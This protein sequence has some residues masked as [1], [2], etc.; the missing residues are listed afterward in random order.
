MKMIRIIPLLIF[1]FVLATFQL[2]T[3]SSSSDTADSIDSPK[4]STPEQTWN[5]FKTSILAGDY[6]TAKKCCCAGKTKSVLR[7]EK[8]AD[9]K[10]K[11]LV[12]TMQTIKKIEQQEGTAKYEVVR[13][14]NGVDFSTFVYFEKVDDDWKISRY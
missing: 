14:I 6:D 11:N 5:V 1:L 8:M 10:R 12:Q 13:N 7:F 2:S 4:F 9:G 3:A